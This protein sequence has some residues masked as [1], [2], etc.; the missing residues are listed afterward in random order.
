MR[1]ADDER[2]NDATDQHALAL[3]HARDV[4]A[5]LARHASRARAYMEAARSPATRRA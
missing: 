2:P 4:S 1:D 5:E 3:N